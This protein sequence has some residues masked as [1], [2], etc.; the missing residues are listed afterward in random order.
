MSHAAPRTGR[1]GAAALAW[2][3]VPLALHLAI[4]QRF[5]FDAP[6]LDDYDSVLGSLVEMARA[7]GWREWLGAV[8]ALQNEH[9]AATTRLIPQLVAWAT[10]GVDFRILV[11]FGT[12]FMLGT[13]AF[14]WS[15][16]R[17][18]VT[19]PLMALTAF[20]VLQWSYN[21]AL[22]MASGALPH[23]GVVFFAFAGLYFALRPGWASA[24]A[25][26]AFAL[27]AAFSQANGLLMMPIAAA[28]CLV[29]RQG[30][31]GLAFA[32]A[33]ALIW[34]A[35]FAGY[36]QPAHHPSPSVA[37]RDPV[38]T[39]QL[40]LV[41]IGGIVPALPI[42]QAVGAA[43]LGGIAWIALRGHWRSHPTVFLWLAFVLLSAAS[44]AVGRAGWGLFHASRYAVNP[45]LLLS[46]LA[47]AAF[48]LTRPW[49]RTLTAAAVVAAAA[50][51]VTQ[52]AVAMQQL[53]ERSF[54]GHLLVDVGAPGAALGLG[55]FHG[56]H[57]PNAAH[58][59]GVLEKTAALGL[60][61]PRRVEPHAP[62]IVFAATRPQAPRMLGAME[63]ASVAGRSVT[64]RGWSDIPATVASRTLTLY[65]PKGIHVARLD[66]LESRPDVANVLRTPEALLSGMR[67]VVEFATEGEAREGAARLCFFVSAPGRQAAM[68]HRERPGCA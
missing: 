33:A 40:F 30:R 39:F 62:S 32:I 19:A 54:M 12:L 41:T 36:T 66:A 50:L 68:L 6:V 22:I 51:S 23:L 16:Y 28:G 26:V 13:L 37:F 52:T 56:M 65:P 18:H 17:E 24:A 67:V 15:E 31:R 34:W 11:L 44:V 2:I 3:A 47:L 43:I 60:Y 48:A 5:W 29:T 45:A 38:S 27:L 8:F 35:Y 58:A 10:G 61:A 1:P 55:R 4:L 63:V 9:R 49:S 21:E 57:H 46:I 25:C 64:F 20:L 53:R 42:A 7:Q 59:A 14:M